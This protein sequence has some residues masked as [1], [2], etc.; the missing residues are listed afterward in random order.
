ML[1]SGEFAMGRA[2]AAQPLSIQSAP[3]I[4]AT[5]ANRRSKRS[6]EA[7][8]RCEADK[9]ARILMSYICLLNIFQC[10]LF[11]FKHR[12]IFYLL[13]LASVPGLTDVKKPG[14]ELRGFPTAKV[15]LHFASETSSCRLKIS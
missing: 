1:F 4:S 9:F 11:E 5:V 7:Q 2:G 13:R 15:E 6:D 8:F 3:V 10:V 14:S 12:E